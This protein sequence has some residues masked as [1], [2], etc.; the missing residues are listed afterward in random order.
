MTILKQ[1]QELTDIM[2]AMHA[3]A[4]QGEWEKVTDLD[5]HRQ[6]F[7]H[8]FNPNKS[9]DSASQLTEQVQTIRAI[10]NKRVQLAV[11]AKQAVAIEHSRLKTKRSQC[12]EYLQVKA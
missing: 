10:D 1:L 2:E 3:H 12:D 7:L 4:V 5:N 11:E 9:T 8:S 6:E